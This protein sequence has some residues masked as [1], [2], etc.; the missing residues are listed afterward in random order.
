MAPWIIFALLS[1]FFA[2]LTAVFAKLGLKDVNSDLATAI[3]TAIILFITWGIVFW[4][5][6]NSQVGTLSKNNWIFL[7]LSAFATGFSWLFYYKALQI[8]KA[9]EVSAIDKGSI[10]FTILL[11]FLF[12]KE[13]LTLRILAGAGLIF[14]G[15][16]VLIWK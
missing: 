8:G 14:A 1:A 10:V 3:R 9:S 6:A 15:M 16:L 11:S 7:T 12:L 5:G 4:K 13:P 2:A